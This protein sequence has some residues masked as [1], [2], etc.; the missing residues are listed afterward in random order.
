MEVNLKWLVVCWMSVSDL[1]SF[2]AEIKL[3]TLKSSLRVSR[4]DLT[5]IWWVVNYLG[6]NGKEPAQPGFLTVVASLTVVAT[7]KT[8]TQAES[9][10][11]RDKLS[12]M[13]QSSSLTRSH[14]FSTVFVM[15]IVYLWSCCIHV[16]T[17]NKI[18][19]K[20]YLWFW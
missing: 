11:N 20:I 3:S 5:F 19:P 7:I 18:L 15:A 6:V 1:L 2:H 17:S 4:T 14:T 8:T 13:I 9:H 16:I 12:F 10:M